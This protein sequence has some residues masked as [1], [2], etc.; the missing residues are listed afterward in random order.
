[1]TRLIKMSEILDLIQIFELRRL[2]NGKK[3]K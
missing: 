3:S 1:M 2:L